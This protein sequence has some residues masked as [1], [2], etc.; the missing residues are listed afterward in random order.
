MLSNN[1][2]FFS[3][4]YAPE[5][6]TFLLR[7]TVIALTP[8]ALKERYLQDGRRHYSEMLSEERPPA[9][10]HMAV[11]K[12]ALR[13]HR[14][15]LARE[16]L[17][18]ASAIAAESRAGEPLGLVSLVRAGCPLGVLLRRALRLLGWDVRHYGV[19]I[20]RDRGIDH[21]ALSLVERECRPENIYFVDGW[22]GKGAISGE[23]SR[24]LAGRDGYD[25]RQPRLAVLADLCGGSRLSASHEDW[26]IPFGLLGAPVAGLISR[27]LWADDGLHRCMVWESLR[28]ADQSRD[29][30]DTV[31]ALWTPDMVAAS[32][33]RPA[34]VSDAARAECGRRSAELVRRIMREYGVDTPNRIKP[35][36]A[37]A[38]RALLRRVPDIVLVH[39]LNDPDVRLLLSLARRQGVRTEEVG[40]AIRPYKAVTIIR[41]IANPRRP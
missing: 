9:P 16:T 25:A 17:A 40:A 35:G 15:R 28:E 18:L 36:I 2:A 29:F 20:I 14:R 32:R 24:S 39:R 4:S 6:I 11:Y 19:S 13:E 23:L 1:P 26:L 37:E 21:A 8:V 12:A 22:T 7:R 41:R 34:A 31:S 38:T 5:D 3:G 33:A 30:V 27:S 10:D